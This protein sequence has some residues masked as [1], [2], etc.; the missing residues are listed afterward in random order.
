MILKCFKCFL[1][2]LLNITTLFI[3]AQT[4]KK[5]LNIL[6]ISRCI[7]ADDF[8]HFITMRFYCSTPRCVI[9]ISLCRFFVITHHWWKK[10]TQFIIDIYLQFWTQKMMSNWKNIEYASNFDILFNFFISTIIR[11]FHRNFLF[12]WCIVIHITKI[13]KT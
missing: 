2:K 13:K 12:W 6:F 7:Y 3:Y 4:Y 1:N 9:T 8:F 11:F 5:S 10:T